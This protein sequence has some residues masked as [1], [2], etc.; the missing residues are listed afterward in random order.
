MTE[1]TL[2]VELRWADLDPNF[3]LRHSVYYDFGGAGLRW[4]FYR[5]TALPFMQQ[6]QVGPILFGR[7]VFSGGKPAMVM[8]FSSICS[9]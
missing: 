9:C 2:P 8:P 1:Y 7:S 4:R 5:K 3:H 6:A